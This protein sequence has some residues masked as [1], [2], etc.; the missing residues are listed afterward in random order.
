MYLNAFSH[1]AEA[2]HL[3]HLRKFKIIHL[4]DDEEFLPNTIMDHYWEKLLKKDYSESED[5]GNVNYYN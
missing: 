3:N 4:V 2:V 1:S 5:W